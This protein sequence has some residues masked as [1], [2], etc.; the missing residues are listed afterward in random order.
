MVSSADLLFGAGILASLVLCAL[1]IYSY[2]RWNEPGVTALTVFLVVLGLS[3]VGGGVASLGIGLQR[4]AVPVWPSIAILG[5][6]FWCLPWGLFGFQYTGRYTRISRRQVGLLT[7]PYAVIVG[8]LLL[9]FTLG[10]PFDVLT[11]VLA[12]AILLYLFGLLAVGIGLVLK[13]S[14]EYAHLS[15]WSGV[16]LSAVPLAP[17]LIINM[18]NLL[19]EPFVIAE[20]YLVAFAIPALG[21]SVSL[22]YYETF[23]GTPAV[24][25]IG[26][27]EIAHTIDDLVFVVDD[28]DHIIKLNDAALAALDTTREAVLGHDFPAVLDHSVDEFREHESIRLDTAQGTRQYDSQV[29][30]VTD[31]HGRGLGVIV[32][33]HDVTDHELREQRLTVLNRVLRHNLRNKIEVVKGN[34]EVLRDE[35]G[36][37]YADTIVETA[38]SIADLGQSARTID[39]FVA[40]SANSVQVDLVAAVDRALDAVRDE[41]T[42]VSVTVDT[43]ETARV[44]TTE[45]ALVGA[46]ESAIDNALTH[47]TSRVEISVTEHDDRYEVAVV[48]D[49]QGIPE[50]ELACIDAG[51][52]TPLQ[53]GTG[54]GLWQLTWAVR[55]MGGDLDFETTD[56]TT[57][58]FTVPTRAQLHSSPYSR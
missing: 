1:G 27:R 10:S 18:T 3:G 13:T 46:L 37:A 55:T 36:S 32:S 52:E 23:E 49:G 9:E 28:D 56:G 43:P 39:R 34:A 15:V 53:H 11:S 48:D 17:V 44:E 29:S 33:L 47:A 4:S 2:R 16:S 26:E 30:T 41:D 21:A 35:N 54:L 58:T 51:T 5:A 19:S 50:N 20:S 40:Q 6:A 24:G 57:V 25:T 38:D 22:L 45:A 42:D 8:F 7:V 12:V 31:Q 14:F